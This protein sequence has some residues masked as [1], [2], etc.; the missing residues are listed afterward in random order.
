MADV[1]RDRVIDASPEDVWGT[2]VDY[3]AI[4]EWADNVEHSCILERSDDG[5]IGLARRV[6]V[7]RNA[8][9]ERIVDHDPPR[10]LAYDIEGLPPRLRTVRNRWTV[11]PDGH[12]RSVVTLVSTVE[13]GPRPPQRLAERVVARVLARQSDVMLAGLAAHV[14]ESRV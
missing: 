14:E 11:T 1:S 5:M 7:G 9:V 13:I 4:G 10:T 12:G 6:Q 2:L 8:L 3:G